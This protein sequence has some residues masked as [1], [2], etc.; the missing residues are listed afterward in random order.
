MITPVTPLSPRAIERG[1]V[2]VTLSFSLL[3]VAYFVLPLD[4]LADVPAIVTLPLALVVFAL[5][6]LYQVRAIIAAPYP[7]MQA[8]EALG[9]L[10]PLFLLIF[11]ATYYVMGQKDPSS[12]SEDL[13]RL[14]ALYFTL[15]TFATVGFGDVTAV[16]PQSRVVVSIQMFLDLIVLGAGIKVILGAVRRGRERERPS[17][18]ELD[19]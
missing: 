15:T 13:S 18:E 1:V 19:D 14:D 4:W 6:L 11:S 10:A 3:V 12:L 17:T 9:V 2:R 7:G 16:T 8:L 5:L